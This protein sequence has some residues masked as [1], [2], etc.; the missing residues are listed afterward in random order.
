[1]PKTA[2]SKVKLRLAPYVLKPYAHDSKTSIGPGAAK[3]VVVQ[4]FDPFTPVSQL[5]AFF[6]S[7]GEIAEV[8]NQI[9]PDTGSFLGVCLIKFRDSK[10]TRGPATSAS[11]SARRAEKEGNGE[12]LGLKT[13]RVERDREGRKCRRSVEDILKRAKVQNARLFP[14]GHTASIPPP[15]PPPPSV[16]TPADDTPAPPPNAPRG[17]AG[18]ASGKA[19]PEKPKTVT[20]AAPSTP[21]HAGIES[22]PVLPKIKRK[23]Y[24]FISSDHVPVLSSTVPHLRKRL[25]A[26][27]WREVR[28]D[29][30]G[31]YVVFEDSKLGEEETVRCYGEING[32]ALFTY[33]MHMECH[34]Y[35]NPDYERS[36]SPETQAS[37]K[38]RQE[39]MDRIRKDAEED[40]EE[41]KKQRAHFLD[42]VLGAH[43]LLVTELRN[44][45]LD[46]LKTK[47]TIPMV[48]ESLD[49]ARHVAKRRKMNIPDP[50][51]HESRVPAMVL[52]KAAEFSSPKGRGQRERPLRP[53]DP[54]SH[55][56]RS[57]R[58]NTTNVYAEERRARKLPARPHARPLIQ[59]L[60]MDAAGDDEGD[61]DDEQRASTARDTDDQESRPLS[62]ASRNSTPFG[63]TESI[64]E[65]I[66]PVKKR[67]IEQEDVWQA[68]EEE[69][70][71]F[72]GVHRQLLG[73]ILRKEPEGMAKRELELVNSTLPR[74]SRFG[75]RCKTELFRRERSKYDDALFNTETDEADKTPA[76]TIHV[77]AE[78]GSN[79][80]TERMTSDQMASNSAA[81][82][83]SKKK[84]KKTKKQIFEEREAL[85][86]A[87]QA[88]VE[89][90][91]VEDD[92][93]N[94]IEEKEKELD[95]DE[96]ELADEPARPQIEW[97]VSTDKPLRTV[98]DDPNLVLDVDGWQHLVKDDED[99][100]FLKKAL[101]GITPA[102]IGDPHYWAWKQKD[103]KASNMGGA[104]GPVYEDPTIIHGYYV[105]NPSGCARTEP[106]KKIAESEKSKYLP[107]RIKV[108]RAR[109]EREEQAKDN[110]GAAAEKARQEA[111]AATANKFTAT[112]SSRTNRANNR[113]L[114]NDINLQRQNLSTT[115]A[116]TDSIRFNQLKKRKKLV[117]FARSAIHGWGLYAQENIAFNDMIIEYVGEIVR[118]KVA[119]LREAQYTKQGIGSSY[120]F[121]ISDD[122]IVDATKK[123]GIARFINHSCTPNC[124]AKIIKVDGTRRIVIYAL[125]DIMASK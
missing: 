101:E 104:R 84:Q 45:I 5:K 62:R 30:T 74:S 37:L 96:E 53:H 67:K 91:V 122:E 34:R 73:D 124:T 27:D 42:P 89:S 107:H 120:L 25:K 78:D 9:D 14:P 32:K 20:S 54:H 125:K 68:P 61:S 33:K 26:F 59:Q 24:L 113:R 57:R 29:K 56:H 105:A 83:R 112:A 115:G 121:R 92:A 19:I 110:P 94:Q 46:D 50:S 75:K 47:I 12:R 100:G 22:E 40:Y 31:Y 48:N 65:S 106:Y 49:P 63:D 11:H 85:K 43:E 1:M 82:E 99:L 60:M 69:Q 58:E 13:I 28:A 39:E 18:R 116:E 41:E 79:T 72:D 3:Q 2:Q 8:S 87:A 119:D 118:Q 109:Q 77:T 90:Q 64:A 23:P 108:L 95:E 52:N 15:P 70:E 80:D 103:I 93:I 76:P 98:E 35:G 21:T 44:K 51:D 16:H 102:P 55:S 38:K 123:G 81:R 7:Y 6:S 71:E 114:V 66:S 4:G 10:H 17:P 117:E 88:V 36:P 111:E 97:A 86:K